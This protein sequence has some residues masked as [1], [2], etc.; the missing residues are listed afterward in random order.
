M[1]TFLLLI[2]PALDDWLLLSLVQTTS[3]R[4]ECLFSSNKHLY[5]KKRVNTEWPLCVMYYVMTVELITTV[6][7]DQHWLAY[8]TCVG[9]GT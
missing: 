6:L 5:K 2:K 4:T 9:L 7:A 8:R 1:L 3:G